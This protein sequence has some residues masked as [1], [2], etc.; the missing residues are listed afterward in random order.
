[1]T[2]TQFLIRPDGTRI[3]YCASP[4]RTAGRQPGVLFCGGFRSDMTGSKALALE[5]AARQRGA[6]FVRFDYFG[7]G[8]SDGNFL[9]GS[10]GRWKDDT[11]VVL[12]EVCGDGPQILVGSSMGGWLATLAAL[13]L[14]E[15]VAGLVLIA[16]ALDFTEDLM[17]AGMSE[18]QRATLLRDGILREP[19]QYSDQPYEYTLK[20]ITEGRDHCILN[21]GI[22]FDK[23]VRILQGMQDPDVPYQHA[24][25][26]IEAFRG[27]DTRLTL[28]KDGDHR[29]SRPQD[30]D[31]LIE[32]VWSLTP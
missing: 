7:H 24:V 31:L 2:E 1:M 29:L 3:A 18:A 27:N 25:K 5:A 23:P 22:A 16:P 10:I 15:K 20:L 30:I 11:L 4:A 32:T 17:W 13:A 14:P 26:T 19:S 8:Q 9:D 28:L 21:A 12:R 6:G